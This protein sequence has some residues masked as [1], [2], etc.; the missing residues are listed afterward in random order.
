MV[1]RNAVTGQFKEETKTF[2]VPVWVPYFY[3]FKLYHL[4]K[5][6]TLT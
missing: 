3:N 5:F 1:N 6:S 2:E 4:Y